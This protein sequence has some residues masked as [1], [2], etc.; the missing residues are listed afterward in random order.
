MAE[1]DAQMALS[2][3]HACEEDGVGPLVDE[4][5]AEE[6]LDL[7]AIDLFRPTPLELLEGF[8]H[9]EAGEPDAALDPPVLSEMNLS[10]DEPLDVLRETSLVRPLL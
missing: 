6:V 9:G 4:G 8:D 2:Q 1:R 7:Q 3:T 10:L 5:Q